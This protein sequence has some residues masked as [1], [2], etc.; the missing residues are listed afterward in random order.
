MSCYSLGSPWYLLF[1]CISSISCSGLFSGRRHCGTPAGASSP[2][3]YQLH[4]GQC[5]I[6]FFFVSFL[7]ANILGPPS[8]SS[9][10]SYN[11]YFFV[12]FY[13]LDFSLYPRRR[14]SVL[15]SSLVLK[16][17]L[18]APFSLSVECFLSYSY[19][20]FYLV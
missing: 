4:L 13:P 8:R 18:C 10:H 20:F 2:G 3:R 15:S 12:L 5:P 6:C 9:L 14:T 16:G 11:I 17:H 1:S 19:S 7:I